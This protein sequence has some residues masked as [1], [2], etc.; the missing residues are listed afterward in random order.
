M[1]N[2]ITWHGQNSVDG[3]HSSNSDWQHLKLSLCGINPRC[4]PCQFL[5]CSLWNET[6]PN[7]ALRLGLLWST[8]IK[9][10]YHGEIR[11][12]LFPLSELP[13]ISSLLMR[14]WKSSDTPGILHSLIGVGFIASCTENIAISYRQTLCE[15]CFCLEWETSPLL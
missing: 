14:T 2:Q 4:S 10:I 5:R 13:V 6:S 3:S 15:Y 1:R 11:H 8:K 9:K 7:F 12:T